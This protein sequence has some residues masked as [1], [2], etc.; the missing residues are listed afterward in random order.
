MLSGPAAHHLVRIREEG[1]SLGGKGPPS[2][3]MSFVSSLWLAV[4]FHPHLITQRKITH[5][6]AGLGAPG[7]EPLYLPRFQSGV[8]GWLQVSSM[9]VWGCKDATLP[10]SRGFPMTSLS[11]LLRPHHPG[12]GL[13]R[14]A[15]SP[16]N[17]SRHIVLVGQ[18][19]TSRR[20][21]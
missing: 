12:S 6:C 19:G 14:L 16:G 11:A 5:L 18:T 8:A 7:A 10:G 21:P 17:D 9:S 3:K 13:W 15:T 1:A 4:G 2:W 20:R